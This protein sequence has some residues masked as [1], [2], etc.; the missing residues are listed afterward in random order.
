MPLVEFICSQSHDGDGIAA[1][2]GP[3]ITLH[4]AKWALCPRGGSEKHMWIAITPTDA[5]VLKAGHGI[6][7]EAHASA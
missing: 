4:Q 7:K 6:V 2:E 1:R 3:G 5:E